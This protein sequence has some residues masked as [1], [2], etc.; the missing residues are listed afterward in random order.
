MLTTTRVTTTLTSG[1]PDMLPA[2]ILDDNEGNR[3]LLKFVMSMAKV[4][5]VEA[6]DGQE[7]LRLWKPGEFGFV[8][9]DIELP[10]INGLEVLRSIRATDPN[11]AIIMCSTNDDPVTIAQAVKD[12]CDLFLIKPF[13]L[14]TLMTLVKTMTP[15][16]L[17]S[18]PH[19][20]VIDNTAHARWEFRC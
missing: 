11:L 14:D 20:L 19:V 10:D 4:D 8:F 9:L 15:K 3:M 13:Q 16:N 6:V 5:C 1:Q 12:G 7:A 17:R 2:L 18:V